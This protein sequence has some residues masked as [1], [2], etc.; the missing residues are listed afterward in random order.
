[1]I[2]DLNGAYIYI[3]VAI[4]FS[5]LNVVEVKSF[6]VR[7]WTKIMDENLMKFR[8]KITKYLDLHN[9]MWAQNSD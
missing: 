2:Y 8:T 9:P 1:M 4:A 7:L 6:L 5:Y 3:W